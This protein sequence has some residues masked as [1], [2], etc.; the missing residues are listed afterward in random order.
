[1][2]K[3]NGQTDGFPCLY[4]PLHLGRNRYGMGDQHK[5]TLLPSFQQL[6]LEDHATSDIHLL[7][8][9]FLYGGFFAFQ[10]LSGG[11]RSS[12]VVESCFAMLPR[13]RAGDVLFEAFGVCK[14]CSVNL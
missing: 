2:L 3:S 6:N 7:G 8:L 11:Q 13:I 12:D 5:Q 14:Q 4:N 10:V 1:V 9:I